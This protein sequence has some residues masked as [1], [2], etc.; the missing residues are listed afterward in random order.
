MDQIHKQNISRAACVVSV[1]L[2]SVKQDQRWKTHW[3]AGPFSLLPATSTFRR[4]EPGRPPN[5][6][7]PARRLVMRASRVAGAQQL[8]L[9]ACKH[10]KI[11]W[12]T[13]FVG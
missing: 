9:A 3:A 12:H 11:T 10:V 4:V 7:H 5:G 6:R 8:A 13:I 1:R 2:R